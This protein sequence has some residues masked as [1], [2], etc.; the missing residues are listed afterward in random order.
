MAQLA[1]GDL[2]NIDA[3]AVG[4]AAARGDRAA[5]EEIAYAGR[6][7]GL[8][9]VTALHLFNPEIIVL[10]GGVTKTGD[11][12]FQPMRQAI[13]SHVLDASYTARLK[14]KAAALG[15]RCGAGRRGGLGG[16]KGWTHRH[17][18]A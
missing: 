14:I 3:K 18:R 6:M 15:R 4:Q 16:D 10:G 12:L 11:L 1:D 5:V 2:G 8:G 7:I 13:D 17:Q 9:I